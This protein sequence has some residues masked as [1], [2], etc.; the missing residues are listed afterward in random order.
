MKTC[1]TR[2]LGSTNLAIADV[3][4]NFEDGY[5]ISRINVP[6]VFRKLGFGS[7]LLDEICADADREQVVLYLHI[8]PSDGLNYSQLYEWYSKRGF[9][10]NASN[11]FE[12]QPLTKS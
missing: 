3:Y 1:Y 9:I 2:K 8:L 10:L 4:G 6:K 12:R 11:W 7:L 5:M